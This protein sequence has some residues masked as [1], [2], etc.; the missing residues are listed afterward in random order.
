M[1]ELAI[2]ASIIDALLRAGIIGYQE[3]QRLNRD[4]ELSQE[5]RDLLWS[6]LDE[7]RRAISD[8][9]A[10]ARYQGPADDVD[11]TPV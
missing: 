8:A 6:R 9:A 4:A 3:I 11:G 2:A 10:R 7:R 1:G 5:A